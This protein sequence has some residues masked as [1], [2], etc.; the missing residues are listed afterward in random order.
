[1]VPE[2]F[3]SVGEAISADGIT[4][5]KNAG[6][7]LKGDVLGLG[8]ESANIGAPSVSYFD[9]RFY[10]FY[11]GDQCLP[12]PT[13]YFERKNRVGWASGT[14]LTNLSKNPGNP[15][16]DVGRGIYSWEN[17]VVSRATVIREGIYYYMF[18][19]G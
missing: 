14:S 5:T 10:V 18:F 9:G 7:I 12:D 8:W 15:V 17:H 6:P 3:G 2:G 16:L 13:C 11:H 4:W 19:E 1:P